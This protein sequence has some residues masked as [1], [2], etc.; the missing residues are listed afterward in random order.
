MFLF[1]SKT[2]A[3]GAFFHYNEEEYEKDL[4]RA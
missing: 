1:F 4:T 2:L 3:I